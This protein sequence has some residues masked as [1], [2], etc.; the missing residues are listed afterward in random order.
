M[1]LSAAGMALLKTSEG[2]RSRVYLDVA[3][4]PT[5]GWGHKLLPSEHSPNGINVAQGE[6]L[7][8][9]KHCREVYR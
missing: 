4:L 2:F 5:V 6:A 3:G 7:L 8:A 9:V 1:N